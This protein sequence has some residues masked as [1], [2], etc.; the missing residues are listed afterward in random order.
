MNTSIFLVTL[1]LIIGLGSLFPSEAYA[2]IDPA[3]ASIM[4]QVL[5]GALV[6]TGIALKMYWAKLRFLLS[7]KR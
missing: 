4:I 3:S 2:Y 7:K 5:I 6:G 1:S